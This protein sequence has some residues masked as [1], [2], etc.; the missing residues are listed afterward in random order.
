MQTTDQTY[1]CRHRERSL[2]IATPTTIDTLLR[3]MSSYHL[4]L[5]FFALILLWL[6]WPLLHGHCNIDMIFLPAGVR[7]GEWW[8]LLAHPLVH[9]TW[10]HLLLDGTAFFIL[11]HDLQQE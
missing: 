10:Y 5:S 11:Y 8:R 4:E 2:V 1:R 3:R 9:V 7:A 6:N